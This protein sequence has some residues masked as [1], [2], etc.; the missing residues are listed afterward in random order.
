[1]PG[2]GSG[3]LWDVCRG[4]DPGAAVGADLTPGVAAR[5]GMGLGRVDRGA[6]ATAPRLAGDRSGRV[7]P[8]RAEGAGVFRESGDFAGVTFRTEP[9]A[10]ARVFDGDDGFGIDRDRAGFGG[11][12]AG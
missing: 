12:A 11:G 6:V 1:M 8:V 5:R 2:M 4:A 7:V 3:L 10:P 9:W